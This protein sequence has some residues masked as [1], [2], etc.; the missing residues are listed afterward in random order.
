[1]DIRGKMID[2]RRREK[3]EYT[4]GKESQDP[5][6]KHQDYVYILH[7]SIEVELLVVARDGGVNYEVIEMNFHL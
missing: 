6:V 7:F 1:M 5:P 3:I 4:T 2:V